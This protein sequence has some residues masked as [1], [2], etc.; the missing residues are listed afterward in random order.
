MKSW[1]RQSNRPVDYKSV[2]P[3]TR[4]LAKPTDRLPSYTIEGHRNLRDTWLSDYQRKAFWEWHVQICCSYRNT[5]ENLQ[6]SLVLLEGL[7]KGMNQF[8]Y[9]ENPNLKV[10]NR[11]EIWL[12]MLFKKS[13]LYS[14]LFAIKTAH[15]FV[16]VYFVMI[17]DNFQIVESIR[18][19][20]QEK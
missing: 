1:W 20:N 4:P 18:K 7:K 3:T 12:D 13:L 16:S 10:K 14:H 19:R 11:R 5:C 6:L 8:L 9:D 15:S 2:V 17:I